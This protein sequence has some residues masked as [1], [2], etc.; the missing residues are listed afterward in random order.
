MRV[1]GHARK[2]AQQR[3]ITGDELLLIATYGEVM[4]R[5]G[6]AL[7]LRVPDKTINRLMR[8]LDS[9]RRKIL[10]TDDDYQTI[11]TAYALTK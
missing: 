5:R 10:I 2:R 7:R 3:G 11:I 6:G 1:S 8:A 9:C 4:D